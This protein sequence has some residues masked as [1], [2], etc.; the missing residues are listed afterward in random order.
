MS[1]HGSIW[2][3]VCAGGI[4]L[5]AFGVLTSL[6]FSAAGALLLVCALVGWVAELR[7]G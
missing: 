6:L 3:V 2:P 4:A 1:E 7:H 5:L